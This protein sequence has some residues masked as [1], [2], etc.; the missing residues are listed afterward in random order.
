MPSFVITAFFDVE[1]DTA[2]PGRDVIARLWGEG[3]QFSYCDEGVLTLVVEV[4]GPDQGYAFETVLSR[5]EEIWQGL[6]GRPLAAPTTVRM[7]Q[8]AP[9]AKVLG[10][11]VG[12]GPDRLMA[13][14]AASR[15]A[16]LRAAVAALSDLQA[17]VS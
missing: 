11:A 16:R 8:A 2:P 10:G 14:A 6:T 5:I 9:R 13:D 12:R 7:R 3:H 17:G 1:P 4:D 15:A